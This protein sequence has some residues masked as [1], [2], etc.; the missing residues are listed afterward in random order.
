MPDD[1]VHLTARLQET[2]DDPAPA[3]LLAAARAAYSWR[4]VDTDLRRPSYDSLLDE[5][6]SPTRGGQD[7][8][9]LRFE[10]GDVALDLEVALDGD[11]RTL[12]GQVSPAAAAEVTVRHGG[13]EETTVTTDELGRFALDG[14]R[15]GPLSVRCQVWEPRV[16]LYTDWLLI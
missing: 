14:V 7:A 4:T 11:G 5:A 10:A 2:D 8:R 3:A 1:P 16:E 13:A 12:V 15:R 6:L 9:L